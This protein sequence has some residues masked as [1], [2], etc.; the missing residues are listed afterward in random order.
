MKIVLLLIFHLHCINVFLE[1]L[2]LTQNYI[3][4]Y[5]SLSSEHSDDATADDVSE[6]ELP[7]EP[8]LL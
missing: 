6:P 1:F 3:Y 8:P 7:S 5:Y 4:N 2:M